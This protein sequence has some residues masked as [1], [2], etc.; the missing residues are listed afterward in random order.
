M[1]ITHNVKERKLTEGG[2]E[3]KGKEHM[4]KERRKKI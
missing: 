1:I 2:K 3:I 4:H